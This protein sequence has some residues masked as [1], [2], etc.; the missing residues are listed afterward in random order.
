MNAIISPIHDGCNLRLTQHFVA[1]S[2]AEPH[3]PMEIP[4]STG[5]GIPKINKIVSR[6]FPSF[7]YTPFAC[8]IEIWRQADSNLGTDFTQAL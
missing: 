6:T 5:Q 2:S 8:N 7:S 1:R 3:C 4:I